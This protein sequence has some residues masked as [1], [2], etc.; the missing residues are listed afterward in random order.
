MLWDRVCVRVCEGSEVVSPCGASGVVTNLNL[1]VASRRSGLQYLCLR[2]C[3][4]GKCV[5][6]T[7]TIFL[8][9]IYIQHFCSIQSHVEEWIMRGLELPTAIN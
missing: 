7:I 1:N 9:V 3:G 4:N 8:S 6:S 5:L 2:V